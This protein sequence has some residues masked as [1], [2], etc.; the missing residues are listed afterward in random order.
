MEHAEAVTQLKDSWKRIVYDFSDMASIFP[1]EQIK[2]KLKQ[3]NNLIDTLSPEEVLQDLQENL[4]F[5]KSFD[6]KQE[7]KTEE[8]ST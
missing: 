4:E 6:R 3:M 2:K 7:T 5:I 8:T 1:G